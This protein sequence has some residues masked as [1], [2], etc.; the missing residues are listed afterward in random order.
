MNFDFWT[1][2]LLTTNPLERASLIPLHD[3]DF[4]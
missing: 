3:Y 4:F 2:V 1:R